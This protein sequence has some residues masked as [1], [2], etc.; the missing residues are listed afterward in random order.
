LAGGPACAP[1]GDGRTLAP[2][3]EIV[4]DGAF[5]LRFVAVSSDSRC[6][7][8][9]DC[10]WPG[11]AAVEIE[12]AVGAGPASPFTLNTYLDPKCVDFS[13]YRVELVELAPH[14][15]GA[16]GGDLPSDYRAHFLVSTLSDTP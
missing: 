8:E 7:P 3:Q 16:G 1:G 12:L 11:N 2:G 6:P 15:P 5:H 4:V 9:D 10:F 13:G 14:F